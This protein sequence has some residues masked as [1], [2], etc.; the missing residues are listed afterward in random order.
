MR[1]D[2]WA[3]RFRSSKCEVPMTSPVRSLRLP[4][5]HAA[6]FHRGDEAEAAVRLQWTWEM[7]P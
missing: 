6:W 2:G 7:L 5:R 4:L 3:Y 1:P